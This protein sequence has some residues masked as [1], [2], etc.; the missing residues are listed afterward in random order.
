MPTRIPSSVQQKLG[1]YVYLYIDPRDESVFY[2]GK[3]KGERALAH[4][5]DSNPYRLSKVVGFPRLCDFDWRRIDGIRRNMFPGNNL[6][7]S[8]RNSRYLRSGLKRV[9]FAHRLCLPALVE[10]TLR[11]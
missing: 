11:N 8:S 10:D 9:R 1:F 2:V 5:K 6:R 7:K 4:L 3:G